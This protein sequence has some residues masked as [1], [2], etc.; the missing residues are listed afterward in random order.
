MMKRN[1]KYVFLYIYTL[2]V[3]RLS[4]EKRLLLPT[5]VLRIGSCEFITNDSWN[6]GSEYF[7]GVTK[8]EVAFAILT[9]TRTHQ[10]GR[11]IQF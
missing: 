8:R 11:N 3:H 7:A 6:R 5:L 1:D 9:R 4:V 2:R 10:N